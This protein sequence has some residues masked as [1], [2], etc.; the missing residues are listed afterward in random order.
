MW[1]MGFAMGWTMREQWGCGRGPA[2][3]DVHLG[4]SSN[5]FLDGVVRH[6]VSGCQ[7]VPGHAVGFWA[8]VRHVFF[9]WK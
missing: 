3:D 8:G 7:R 9:V 1:R 2:Q 6:A 5:T 4:S